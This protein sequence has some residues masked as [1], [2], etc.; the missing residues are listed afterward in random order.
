M[1]SGTSFISKKIKKRILKKISPKTYRYRYPLD[2]GS[3][4]RDLGTEIWDP[5][6]GIRDLESGKNSSRIL[7]PDPDLGGKKA[8]DPGSGSGSGSGTLPVIKDLVCS[9]KGFFVF[10]RRCRI[11]AISV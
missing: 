1:V 6:P 10:C 9:G 4:N 5:R 3:G 11:E 7:I 2:P 8:P